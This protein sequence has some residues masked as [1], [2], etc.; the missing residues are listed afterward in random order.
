[1]HA[2]CTNLWGSVMCA[3]HAISDSS[4][5][6]FVLALVSKPFYMIFSFHGD[7][8]MKSSGIIS[9]L[10]MELVFSVTETCLPSLSCVD[11]RCKVLTRTG[12]W[13]LKATLCV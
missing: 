1:M 4:F 2:F 12:Q 7:H 6:D 3:L 10:K 8:T 9:P 5:S 13:A 11:V